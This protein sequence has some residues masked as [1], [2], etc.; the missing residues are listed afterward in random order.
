MADARTPKSRTTKAAASSSTKAP[1][2]ALSPKGKRPQQ[3]KVAK[4][5]NDRI[6]Y[7]TWSVFKAVR[8]LGEGEL[9]HWPPSPAELA[10][11]RPF[12]VTTWA[13]ALLKWG[14][15]DPR[16]HVSLAATAH[17]G[18]IAENAAAGTTVGTACDATTTGSVA[19]RRKGERWRI[20]PRP[21]PNRQATSRPSSAGSRVRPHPPCSAGMATVRHNGRGARCTAGAAGASSMA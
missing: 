8:P 6:R 4:E 19:S 10:P 20:T 13:Q 15:S 17:P 11:L 5:I 12:A 16:V 7:T 1:A 18:R 21:M 3:G 14:L 9:M 2:K